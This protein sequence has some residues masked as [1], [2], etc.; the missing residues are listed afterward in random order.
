M[1]TTTR[2]QAA[3]VCHCLGL[4]RVLLLVV[5]MV[6]FLEITNENGTHLQA[7]SWNNRVW[8]SPRAA[9]GSTRSTRV[10]L[11]STS[12]VG[13][14]RSCRSLERGATLSVMRCA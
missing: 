6:G 9:D 10:C 5:V 4:L 7:I 12:G 1:A 14:T 11:R 8:I 3:L 13:Q 2:T